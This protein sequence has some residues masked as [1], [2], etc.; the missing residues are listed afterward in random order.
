MVGRARG[1]NTDTIIKVS[2]NG[3]ITS[4]PIGVGVGPESIAW[5]PDS[6]IW[7]TEFWTGRIGRMTP[8]GKVTEF[9]GGQSLRGIVAGPDKNL[10]F[11]Q[12]DFN[13][14]GIVRM[15]VSGSTT[16]FPLG[17]SATDQLQPTG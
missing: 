11:V 12:A 5:G 16:F 9:P 10:W 14:T 6:N 13:H 1:N 3:V 4:F 15:T 17:G 2:P 8:A 7:F